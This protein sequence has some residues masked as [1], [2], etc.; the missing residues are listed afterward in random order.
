MFGGG[1]VG[2]DRG[3]HGRGERRTNARTNA[4]TQLHKKV[5]LVAVAGLETATPRLSSRCAGSFEVQL[6]G[7]YSLV[8]GHSVKIAL[9]NNHLL[10]RSASTSSPNVFC[11]ACAQEK[12]G[13]QNDQDTENAPEEFTFGGVAQV[14]HLSADGSTALLGLHLKEADGQ[15]LGLGAGIIHHAFACT[16]GIADHDSLLCFLSFFLPL[17]LLHQHP[18]H[19]LLI[20]SFRPC[21]GPTVL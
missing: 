18:L 14:L 7:S 21:L 9:T 4:R 11:H 20:V 2:Q 10:L 17:P 8:K 12:N 1:I 19:D 5:S 13:I 3:P 15:P 16:F 6:P